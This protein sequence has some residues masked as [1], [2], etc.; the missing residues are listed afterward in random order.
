MY[1]RKY[2]LPLAEGGNAEA[3][4]IVPPPPQS[5]P[6]KGNKSEG[7]SEK[8]GEKLKNIDVYGKG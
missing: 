6:T 4:G 2:N 7:W 3:Q 5:I 1:I 8:A